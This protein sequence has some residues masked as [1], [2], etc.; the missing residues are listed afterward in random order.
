MSGSSL[1]DLMRGAA[2]AVHDR[3][4]VGYEIFGR[5]APDT[6]LDRPN[7]ALFYEEDGVLWKLLRVGDGGW[8]EGPFGVMEPWRLLNL[9]EDPSESNDLREQEPDRFVQLNDMYY[10]YEQNVGIIPQ[11][12]LRNDDVRPGDLSS[13]TFTLVNDDSITETYYLYCRSGWRCRL[14]GGFDQ[15]TLAPG[16][17]VDIDVDVLVPRKRAVLGQ[18]RTTQVELWRENK[19]AMSRNQ[20]LVTKVWEGP[21]SRPISKRGG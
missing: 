21:E 13:F 15:V 7:R 4:P 9:T 1:R 6:K 2:V 16:E 3:E 19:P 8:G 17:L 14:S 18:V 20:I 5:I 12:A 11:S 10:A